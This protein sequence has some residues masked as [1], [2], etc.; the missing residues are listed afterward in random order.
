VSERKLCINCKHYDQGECSD[1]RNL[2]LVNNKPNYPPEALRS[3]YARP[4]QC[5]VIGC[6][7]EEKQLS[8]QQKFIG[9]FIDENS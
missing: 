4:E 9:K 3:I 1:E 5:G 8:R 2:S 6:W 7:F